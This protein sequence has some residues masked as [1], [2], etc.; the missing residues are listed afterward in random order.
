MNTREQLKLA[1]A[2][3]AKGQEILKRVEDNST[4]WV[5]IKRDIKPDNS[6]AQ[7]QYQSVINGWIYCHDIWTPMDSKGK[8]MDQENTFSMINA[9]DLKFEHV[10]DLFDHCMSLPKGKEALKKT[11]DLSDTSHLKVEK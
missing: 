11:I 2:T 5:F 3:T 10:F 6:G 7:R 9:P 4:G 1:G 8:W